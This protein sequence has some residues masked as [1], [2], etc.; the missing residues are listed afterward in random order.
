RQL[1]LRS[2]PDG[3]RI[4]DGV[5][6]GTYAVTVRCASYAAREHY[7]PIVV[8]DRDVSGVV[9]DVDDGA[10]I[11]GRVLSKSGAALDGVGLQ[12]QSIDNRRQ[13]AWGFARSKA[14]GRFELG[15]LP[16]G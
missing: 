9:W 5:L 16:P 2:E 7:D 10:R 13:T 8:G 6:P 12:S 4:A 1:P 15:G 3:Q 11:R 14:D